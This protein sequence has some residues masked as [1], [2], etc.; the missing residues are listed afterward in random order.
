VIGALSWPMR[1]DSFF[2]YSTQGA[3][4]AVSQMRGRRRLAYRVTRI[5]PLHSAVRLSKWFV[6]GPSTMKRYYVEE[7]ALVP[8]R[9]VL[10]LANDVDLTEYPRQTQIS[11]TEGRTQLGIGDD[12]VV[13][14]VV[15]RLSPIRKSEMYFDELAKLGALGG[16]NAGR[17]LH[18]LVVGGGPE[19]QML[20]TRYSCSTG[21][22]R[23]T[24][25]GAVPRVEVRKYLQVA[26]LF[27]MPSYAEGFPRVLL[28][29]MAT[30][31]PVVCTSAGGSAEVVGED[32][33]ENVIDREDP[34]RFAEVVHSL[35]S[36][37]LEHRCSLAE[38]SFQ[39]AK[40]FD[41]R[42]VVRDFEALLVSNGSGNGR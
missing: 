10:I 8:A 7:H 40:A 26:D 2:W 15:H 27:L 21:H 1:Y 23:I 19:L 31:L 30:G 24:F 4:E 29:A 32:L 38:R 16:S 5:A 20:R 25:I 11:K 13:A 35:A 22:L 33:R 36:S 9:K 18:I 17:I 41:T 34:R 14:L 37:S 28:E 12:E 6:T 3:Q 42:V 39:R